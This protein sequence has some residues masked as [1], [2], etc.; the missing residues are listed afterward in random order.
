MVENNPN[1]TMLK[2]HLKERSQEELIRDIAEL[3]K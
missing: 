2:R 1:L 3:F